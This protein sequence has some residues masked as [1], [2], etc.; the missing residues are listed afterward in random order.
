MRIREILLPVLM[1]LTDRSGLLVSASDDDAADSWSP[2]KLRSRAEEAMMAGDYA[3][4]VVYLH[5]AIAQEPT[6]ALNHYKLYRLYSRRRNYDSALTHVE[7]AAQLDPAKYQPDKARLL[8]T[9]G[10]CDRAVVEYEV[11]VNGDNPDILTDNSDY[12][13][14]KQCQETIQGANAAYLAENY[15]L[16]AALYHQALQFVEQGHD[17]VWPKAVSLFH[18]GD[19]YGVISDTGRLLK[20]DAQNIDAY[21]LRGQAYHRLGDH[22]QAVL[23]FREG[24]KLDPEH[25]ECKKGHKLVKSLEKKKKK[26][27][28]AFDKGDYQAAVDHWIAAMEIDPTHAAFNRPLLLQVAKAY[29]KLQKHDQ[30]IEMINQHL[31]EQETVEGLWALGDAQQKADRYNEAVQT[32]SQAAELATD[33]LK[34]EARNKLQQAQVALKQ[35]KEKNYYK[36]LGLA[37]SADSKEIKKA[38]RD[39]ARQWHPD[40][41]PDN[42]E[43]AEKMFMDIGEA[44]EVL[45]DDEL[46]ARYDRGEDVFDNQGGGRQRAN[47]HQFFHQHFQQGGGQQR[48]GGGPRFHF[49]HG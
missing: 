17:L 2:G 7:T 6:S 45:S 47:P 49:R 11:L 16:A 37:R 15:E 5:K 20:A 46:K 30:A 33:D 12:L 4:A 36:I 26:G 42:I 3:T 13:K 1:L 28:D 25:A 41:N 35:S 44:Y 21:R 18:I 39:L 14:A 22:D 9:L 34:Q 19:Y 8:L 24:L 29:S 40:K 23:H 31:S 38:Y 48:A 10:Q 32:F 27:Q 43:E